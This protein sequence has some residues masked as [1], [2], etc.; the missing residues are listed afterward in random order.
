M[1]GPAAAQTARGE[2]GRAPDEFGGTP[3]TM[4]VPAAWFA[5]LPAADVNGFSNYAYPGVPGGS[6][7]GLARLDLPNGA[8]ITRLCV[9]AFDSTWHGQ[10]QVSLIGWE[11]PAA[12]GAAP[13]PSAIVATATSGYSELP[14]MGT[15]C[16]VPAAPIRVRSMGDLDNDG[17]AGWTAY[18]LRGSLMYGP[19]GGAQGFSDGSVAFGA[20]VVHWRRTVSPAPAAATFPSDVPTSHPFFRFVEALAASGISGG[21]GPGAYC[22]DSAVTRG[23]MAVFL[24]TALGLHW[25][26]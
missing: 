6:V 11:Y 20:A 4:T 24:A 1:A 25:T 19:G 9:A 8:E 12:A 23:E 10:A 22:P 14:G 3:G 16:L 5:G 7:S 15:F 18:A 26:N 17:D 13:T 21:C 2:D